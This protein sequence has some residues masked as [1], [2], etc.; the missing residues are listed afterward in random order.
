MG[1]WEGENRLA[2][3]PRNLEAQE[4]Q[5]DFC[6]D[7]ADWRGEDGALACEVHYLSCKDEVDAGYWRKL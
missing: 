7:I 1:P 5:C 6:K 2:L 4:P 3:L